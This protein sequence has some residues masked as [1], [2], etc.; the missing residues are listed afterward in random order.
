LSADLV[1]HAK[2]KHIKIDYYFVR[3]KVAN[4][5]VDIKYISSKDKITHRFT[6]AWAV[7]AL[8]EFRCNLNLF[9]RL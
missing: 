8:E 6:K 5:L 7:K 3:E 1:F 2:A 4:K 9:T